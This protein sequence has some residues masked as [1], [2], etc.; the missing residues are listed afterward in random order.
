MKKQDYKI[1][2]LSNTGMYFANFIKNSEI[3]TYFDGFVFSAQE[4]LVKPHAAIYEKLLTRYDLKADECLFIDDLPENAKGAENVGMH[5]F[6]FKPNKMKALKD[7][8]QQL[9]K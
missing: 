6:V 8:I 3:G 4:K 2:G 5:G 9:S 7:A 1:Y